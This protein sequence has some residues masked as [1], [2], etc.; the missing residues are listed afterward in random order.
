MSPLEIFFTTLGMAVVTLLSRSFFLIP[1]QDL[2]MPRWLREGLRYAPTAAFAAIVAPEL[3]MTR[4]TDRHLARR[5]HLRRRCGHGFLCVAA[6]PVLHHRVRNGRHAGIAVR[7][8]LVGLT[9]PRTGAWTTL[10]TTLAIQALV[11]MA[12]LAVPAMAPAMA[13][14]LGVSP[15]LIGAYVAIVYIGAMLASMLA[16]PL[17][18]RYGAIRVSQLG[19]LVCAAGLALLA[20]APG[21]VSTAIGA[22]LVGV[23]YGPIIRPAPTCSPA[24]RHRIVWPWCSPSSRRVFRWVALWPGPSFQRCCSQA[25]SMPRCSW[26][27]SATSFARSYRSRC[28]QAWTATANRVVA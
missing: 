3:V 19:L 22:F 12:V 11:A 21:L 20:K 18:I 1:K 2:P 14:S 10:A 17:V 8:G 16:G 7:A 5:A 24:P 27:R 15:P 26:W 4:A 23:G 25:V 13:E 28:A 9:D 6:Q